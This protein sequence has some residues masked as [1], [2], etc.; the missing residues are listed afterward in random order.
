MAHADPELLTLMALGEPVTDEST[1]EHVRSCAVCRTE[2]VSLREIAGVGRE[3]RSERDLPV[4]SED[5]WLRIAEETGQKSAPVAVLPSRRAR[6]WRPLLAVAAV[7]AIAG[8]AGTILVDRVTTSGSA[9]AD[10][11]LVQADLARLPSAPATANGTA[12]VVRTAGHTVLRVSVDGMPAPEG[13]Y[14]VWLFDGVT[15]MIPLGVLTSGQVDLPVPP[16][17]DLATY[18]VVDVSAQRL[19]Q[20]EHGTSMLRGNLG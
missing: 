20:Q 3:T 14:Q 12:R 6:G 13:L 16:G 11:V 5:V 2:L 9:V 7:A 17:V 10:Q 15:T 19:G 4:P 1:V 18:R 8:S